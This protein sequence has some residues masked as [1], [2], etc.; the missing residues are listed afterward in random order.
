MFLNEYIPFYFI[1]DNK[2]KVSPST[3]MLKCPLR[4]G[5]GHEGDNNIEHARDSSVKNFRAS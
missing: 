3:A 4:K 1:C 5:G 2:A